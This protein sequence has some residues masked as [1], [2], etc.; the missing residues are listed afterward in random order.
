[1]LDKSVHVVLR[2]QVQAVNHYERDADVAGPDLLTVVVV[3]GR[4][5]IP[6]S[7]A[8]TATGSALSITMLKDD[9]LF[10]THWTLGIGKVDAKGQVLPVRGNPWQSSVPS[11]ASRGTS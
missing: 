10:Q 8:W 5:L 3:R 4:D 1:V 9:V 11:G 6:Q 7:F 2:T